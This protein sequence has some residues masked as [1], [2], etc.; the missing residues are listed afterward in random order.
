MRPYDVLFERGLTRFDAER[1]HHAAFRAIR[2]ARPVTSRLIG[3]RQEGR[4]GASAQVRAMGITFPHAARP[5]GGLRQERGGHRR[6][7]R[8][9]LRA[10]RGRHGHRGGAAGQPAA[11]PVPAH[12]R[13]RDRQPDGLQQRRC[14]GRRASASPPGGQPAGR[15]S[16][17]STSAR[18]RSCRRT[19]PSPTT[20]S[21]PGCWRPT[22]TTS[23]STCPRPTPRACATSRPSRS[24]S[25]CSPPYAV[26]PTRSAPR[27]GCRCWSRSPRTSATTT[28]SRSPTSRS[29][30]VSTASSPPTPR[31]AATASR[32]ARPT[33]SGCGAGGLSGRPLTQRS[34]DVVRLLRGRVGRDLTLIGVGG[35]TTVDDAR[36][37]LDAGADLLQAYTAFVYEGPLWPRRIVR[38][39][40]PDA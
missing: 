24:S 11:A 23:S 39:L 2:A 34:E 22:P 29:R 16:S 1:I 38:G 10:R 8:A 5:R 19:R 33:W 9:R 27:A 6:A 36:R 14:R 32:A 30:A 35:I 12:R 25:P 18:P 40:A 13:P 28:S 4:A 3:A 37:R 17:A 26:A 20:R 31:S 21:P 15:R 7:G